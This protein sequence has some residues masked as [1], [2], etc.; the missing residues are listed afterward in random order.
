M[1]LCPPSTNVVGLGEGLT[2]QPSGEGDEI[3]ELGL[4]VVR[5]EICQ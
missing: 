2:S 5:F 1:Q 3:T 4:V